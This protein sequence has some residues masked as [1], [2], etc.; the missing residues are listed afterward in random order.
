MYN[1]SSAGLEI[2]WFLELFFLIGKEKVL[3]DKEIIQAM[4]FLA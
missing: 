3:F 1:L 4:K 2:E